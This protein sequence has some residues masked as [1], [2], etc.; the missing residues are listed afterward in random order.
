MPD[1]LNN[2]EFEV[3]KEIETASHLRDMVRS[4]GW[5]IF[6]E[7]KDTR[8]RQIE[9]QVLRS[10][11]DKEALWVTQVRCQGITEFMNA[12]IEGIMNAVETLDPQVLERMLRTTLRDPAEF[13]GELGLEELP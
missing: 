8:I 1:D 7:L 12:L 4:R 5:E 11:L 2:H 13:E 10:R 9:D 3:L 6:L